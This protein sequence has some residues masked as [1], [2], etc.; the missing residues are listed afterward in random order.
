MYYDRTWDGYVD[1]PGSFNIRDTQTEYQQ[2]KV[3]KETASNPKLLR[4]VDER[5][6][7]LLDEDVEQVLGQATDTDMT[8]TPM[9]SGDDMVSHMRSMIEQGYTDEQI[10][11]LHPE[12]A[13]F[14]EDK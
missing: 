3:A 5:L 4:I 1:Y 10:K 8:H 12:I 11:Q 2:L 6:V 9:T 14:F 7:E 13:G